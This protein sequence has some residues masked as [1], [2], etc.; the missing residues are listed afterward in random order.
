VKVFAYLAVCWLLAGATSSFAD[1]LQT[2]LEG[3]WPLDRL[4][5]DN[6]PDISKH[7]RDAA[8]VSVNLTPGRDG[9]VMAFNGKQSMLFLPDEP[10]FE[11]T[12]GYSV[13]FWVRVPVEG[14]SDAPIFA[15]PGFSISTFR[16]T[17]RVTIRNPEYPKT[18]YSDLMGPQINDDTW[19]HVVF[20]YSP[21]SGEGLLYIDSQEALSRPFLHKPEV[22]APT[23]IG[24]FGRFFFTGELSDLRIYSRVLE[25]AEVDQLRNTKLPAK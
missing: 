25:Y 13:S 23:T 11:V 8:A 2:G 3:H 22:S 1:T 21:D 19:H 5:G 6:T 16:G 18:G 9:S 20:T 7:K 10:A 12:G 4:E 15:Q 17:L 14:G 24:G